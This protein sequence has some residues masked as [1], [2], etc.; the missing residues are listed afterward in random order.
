MKYRRSE[1]E[2]PIRI[3][4]ISEESEV[5]ENEFFVEPKVGDRR[6][7]F[8]K[9]SVID[10][11]FFPE[12]LDCYPREHLDEAISASLP[13]FC[14]TTGLHVCARN[15]ELSPEFFTFVLTD[16]HGSR[17]YGACLKIYEETPKAA[18]DSLKPAIFT[19]FEELYTPKVLCTIS[20]YSFIEQFKQ[21]LKEVYKFHLTKHSFPIEVIHCLVLA[22]CVQS[23]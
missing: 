16:Q 7:S 22:A 8:V 9:E 17:I 5:E 23:G 10:V 11:E 3:V 12:I 20:K 21:I 18:F 13:K 14:F 2:A 1:N 15:C 4:K 6:L 19:D